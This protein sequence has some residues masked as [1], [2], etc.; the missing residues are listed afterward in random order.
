MDAGLVWVGPDPDSI[1][2]MGLKDEA[3]ARM[4][5]AGVPVTP[6]YLG[7]DQDPDNLAA[8]AGLI[9]YPVLIKAIAGGGGKGMRL[10]AQP[11]DFPTLWPPVAAR[12]WPP[13]A[14]IGC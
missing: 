10:V 11:S 1:T 5:A 7:Q 14:M 3:K 2:A 6:G 12:H 9:G 8:Q 4:A 13:L